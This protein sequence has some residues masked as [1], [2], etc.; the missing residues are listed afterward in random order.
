MRRP[1]LV[2][3]ALCAAAGVVAL[4]GCG[5]DDQP[6]PSIQPVD[7]R[8]LLATLQEVE[9]NVEVGS[10]FVA[11]D[12][13]AELR[14]E[15]EQL[16]SDVNSDVRTA[17]EEGTDRL[18]ALVPAECESDQPTT[19][20]ETTTEEPTTTEE[21]TTEEPTTDETTTEETQPTAPTT[22]TTPTSPGGGG[23]APGDGL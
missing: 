3:A 19:T 9:D 6:D 4:A 14:S 16:P 15:I 22:P 7:A 21:T 18:D 1:R 5:G 8:T 10:C 17:L 12:K 2:S 13:V 20:T 23:I 11:A